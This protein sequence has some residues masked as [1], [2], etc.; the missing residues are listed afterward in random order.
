M[1]Q[2]IIINLVISL[3]RLRP[4]IKKLDKG[5]YKKIMNAFKEHYEDISKRT[6]METGIMVFHKMF[7]ITGLA[8]YKALYISIHDKEEVI[9]I[10]EDILWKE[11]IAKNIRVIAFFIRLSKD[12][13]NNYLKILGPFNEWFFPCPPWE[14]ERVEIENG[15]GWHQTKC[16]HFEF[17]K[18]EGVTE[19]MRAYCDMDERIAEFFP[20]YIELRRE[21]TLGK[22]DDYCDFLYYKR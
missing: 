17:F 22:G 7:L 14:K 20:D 9:D 11:R 19:L 18:K 21:K 3:F 6:K 4:A 13:F 1:N 2:K 5:N 8:L 10:I 15:I 12:P 16:P